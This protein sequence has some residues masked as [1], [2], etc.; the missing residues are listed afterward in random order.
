M[1]GRL[2]LI[3]D[4]VAHSISPEIQQPALDALGINAIYEL[5]HT[6]S[7]DLEKRINALKLPGVMGANV[8]VPHKQ[9][10]I[11]FLDT[12][13]ET[14]KRAGA[15]NT[16]VP[17]DGSLH[18]DNTDVYGLTRSLRERGI[19]SPG[20]QAIV[21]GAGGAARASLLALEQLEAASVTVVN[22]TVQRAE[23]LAIQF[24]KMDVRARSAGDLLA[25]PALSAASVLINA[26]SIGW[27]VG[28][29]PIHSSV[30]DRLASPCLVFD[31]TY[32]DTPL[33]IEARKRDLQTLDGLP[34]LVLQGAQ[35]FELWTGL[36]A[37]VDLMM[38]RG[39]E[40]RAARS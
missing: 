16:I 35:A 30:L 40:A 11:P 25:D 9:A 18:G 31:L 12:L 34:M 23:D 6:K 32:R 1:S 14:A 21:L 2:G 29:M 26:T 28:E 3:G 10:V 15:V 8:T 4:P 36:R 17:R 5:W 22:R 19:Q 20:F 7:A 38:E 27:T 39:M 33:L 13:S 37:P 24:S